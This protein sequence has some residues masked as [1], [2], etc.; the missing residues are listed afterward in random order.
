MQMTLGQLAEHVKAELCGDPDII[1]HG[2]ATLKNAKQGEITFLAN[3]KYHNQLKATKASA[4]I[5][6]KQTE[7]PAAQLIADDPYYAFTQIIVLLHG[8]RKHKF[9]GISPKASIDETANI[10]KDCDISDFVT[11]SQNAKIGNRTT[12]Y[13]GVFIGP[14]TKIGD[15]CIIYPNVTIY[16]NCQIGNNVIIQANAAIANDGFGFATHNGIHHKIP[17]IG[18][19]VIEDDVEIGAS[20]VIERGTLDNTII[21]KGSKVWDLVAIGHGTKI[22]PYCLIVPQA[23]IAGSTTLGH[24]CVVGG[25]V[26][27]T[28]HINIGNQVMIAAQAGVINDIEDGKAVLGGPAVE[29]SKAKRAYA[30]IEYLPDIRKKVIKVEK[31]VTKL[32]QNER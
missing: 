17:H 29:A 15:D 23:G 10:G 32:E 5:L 24:H 27:I 3:R 14:G 7:T 21:G 1:I 11:V 9:T 12:V 16:D 13:P 4:V 19:V 6:A 31:R 30:L 18:S 28:G 2:A 26:G 25:Q 22:G 20:C 8:H